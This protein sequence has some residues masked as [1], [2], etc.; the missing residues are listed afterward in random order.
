MMA[1]FDKL[2]SNALI[3]PHRVLISSSELEL[4]FNF[5]DG[6]IVH[7]LKLLV[8]FFL[9]FLVLEKGYERISVL[10]SVLF[11]LFLLFLVLL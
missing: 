3:Y 2:Q 9:H 5:I 7:F 4:A 1:S 11:L 8:D 10:G 6:K